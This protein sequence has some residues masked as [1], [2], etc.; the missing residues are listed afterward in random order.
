MNSNQT[1][2]ARPHEAPSAGFDPRSGNALERLFFNHRAAVLALC[3]LITLVL[4][5]QAAGLRLNANF[6]RMIPTGH[7]YIANYLDNRSELAGL[8][9]SLRIAVATTGESIY[10]AEY[11]ATLQKVSEEV[12]LMPGVDRATMKSLWTP[13]T[14]WTGVTEDGLDGGPV[15]P[16]DYDASTQ[17]VE[18]V[19][20]NVARSREVGQ[21]VGLDHKSSIVFMPLLATD[22]E[23]R[24]IDYAALSERLEDLRDKY[25]SDSIHIHVTGFA[26]VAGDLIE[27]LHGVVAFFA[28]A[29][30]LAGAVL[31]AY[32]RCVR[33]TL[34]VVTCSLIAVVW[35]FGL[36][37]TFGYELDPYSMLVPFI[38]FAI[39]M[40]HGAQVMNGI[41]R[42]IG[43][44]VHRYVAA[45][46]TFRRLFVVGLTAL[47]TDAMGFA[48]L[49][50]IDIPV[51]R[52]LATTASIGV[53][54]LI[55][56]NLVLLPIL[57]SH[58]GVSTAAAE[59]SRRAELADRSG[60]SRHPLWAVLD[61]FTDRRWAAGAIIGATL[62]AVGGLQLGQGLKI[63]DLDPGAP[64]LRPDSRY[65]RDNAYLT[66]H[67]GASSDVLAVMVKTPEGECT[68]YDTL[69]RLDALEHRLRQVEGVESTNSL[70]LLNRQVMVGLAEG[71]PKWYDLSPNQY[72]LNTITSGA[73]RGLYNDACSLLTFYAYLTDHKAD[74]LARVVAEA[75][76]FAAANDN[77]HASFLLA[78]GNAGIEAAT[79]TVVARANREMLLWV[80]GV[81]T[82]L[83]L[84]TF[85][86][87]RAVLC[88]IIPLALTSIL[89][90]ALMVLL[91]IGVKVATLPVIVLGVGIGIDYALYVMSIVLVRLK[92]GERL[93]EAYYGALLSTGKVVMLTGATLAVGVATWIF[94]PIKFQADMGILLAFMFLWNMFGALIL[95]PALAR[96]LMPDSLYARA[97]RAGGAAGTG[98]GLVP[99]R[100]NDKGNNP[101]VHIEETASV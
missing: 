62:L 20:V 75:E 14:R 54:A 37:P 55:L 77:P 69:M 13:S 82:L 7:P 2:A 8:G 60:S 88:A 18:Q 32:S 3:L 92:E 28:V 64:E 51:I 40:S 68:N 78:A 39:G 98:H 45:R 76:A 57:L 96:F 9:N 38:V 47:V 86:S 33:S 49:L 74:T 34:L 16:N 73:P 63:G 11:L 42:D 79:N 52:D 4:G 15:I 95:L 48:V 31:F 5:G 25:Q 89:C 61:R 100:G 56:T 26:K 81:V 50:V 65:N 35:Q 24:P 19:R 90:E 84:L 99:V 30:A 10:D 66:A 70:A 41:T 21:L 23:G 91:G 83:C 101:N 22:A 87:W 17:A 80:Y 36:L 94:S 71:N 59:R 6:E 53:A 1:T 44:G 43:Q 67:Y 93:A 12:F 85:R 29:I 46:L 72:M 58:V 97:P 27:G